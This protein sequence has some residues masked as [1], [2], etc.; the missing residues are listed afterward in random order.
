M[1]RDELLEFVVGDNAVAAQ[2]F[3]PHLVRVET[4][5]LELVVDD[6][7]GDVIVLVLSLVV[8]GGYVL[9]AVARV[10]PDDRENALSLLDADPPDVDLAAQRLVLEPALAELDESFLVT[11]VGGG[12]NAHHAAGVRDGDSLHLDE[13]EELPADPVEHLVRHELLLDRDDGDVVVLRLVAGEALDVV[14]QTVHELLRREASAFL[15]EPYEAL[16][17]VL[18]AVAVHRLG[19]AVRVDDEHVVL[20]ELDLLDVDRAAEEGVVRQFDAD[21]KTSRIEEIGLVRLGA[22]KDHRIVAGRRV[23]DDA[24]LRI[25]D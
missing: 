23:A 12:R 7:R 10:L 6:R 18:F 25:E 16:L 5:P 4:D 1:G 22:E 21:G 9:R 8:R 17:A 13:I 2:V 3:E 19:H 20:L 11:I 24:V 15:D 14:V